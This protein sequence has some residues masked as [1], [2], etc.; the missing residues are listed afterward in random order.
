MMPRK[1][2]K[3][4]SNT[5]NWMTH[6]SSAAMTL[7]N[8]SVTPGMNTIDITAKGHKREYVPLKLCPLS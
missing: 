6:C 2:G 1:S 4:S 5:G 3:P 8:Y 7:I